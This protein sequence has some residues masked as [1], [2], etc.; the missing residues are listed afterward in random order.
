MIQCDNIREEL[1]YRVP[2]ILRS[3]HKHN[4]LNH[5][6]NLLQIIDFALEDIKMMPYMETTLSNPKYRVITV[7]T[8]NGSI[9]IPDEFYIPDNEYYIQVRTVISTK[10]PTRKTRKTIQLIFYAKRN[11]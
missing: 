3:L 6:E 8:D 4:E 5:P 10:L 11:L 2:L 9:N 7:F 1:I